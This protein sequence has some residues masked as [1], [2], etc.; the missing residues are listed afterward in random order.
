[1]KNRVIS[2]LI[3]LF[4]AFGL[5]GACFNRAAR[6]NPIPFPTLVMPYEYIDA[7]ILPNESGIVCAE[8]DGL[9]PFQNVGY[10]NVTMYYPVP[11]NSSE[12]TVIEQFFHR[13][14]IFRQELLDS[15]W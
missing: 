4:L 6:T 1:M 3:S 9:Y 10:E 8:V 13:L 11:P 14:E 2:T 7:A 5:I 12:I 15:C